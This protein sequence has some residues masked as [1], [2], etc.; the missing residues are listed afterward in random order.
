MSM[1]ATKYP[2]EHQLIH[3]LFSGCQTKII[4]TKLKSFTLTEINYVL[5]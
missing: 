5:I 1:D 3:A 2:P 4:H